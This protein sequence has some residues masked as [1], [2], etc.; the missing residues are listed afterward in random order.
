L[1]GDCG[2]VATRPAGHVDEQR[3]GGQRQ[4]TLNHP[5]RRFTL[6]LDATLCV[7]IEPARAIVDRFDGPGSQ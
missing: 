3:L 4:T 6:D 7:P 2:S 1:L 5:R